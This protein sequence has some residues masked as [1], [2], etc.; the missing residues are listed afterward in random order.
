[1]TRLRVG[2]LRGG[3]SSEYEISLK[4]GGN[5]LRNLSDDLYV[6]HDILISRGGVWHMR[7]LE[8]TPEKVL[9]NV[10]VVFN[11]L[12]G[13][14]GEDGE[15]QK[16]LDKF[17]VPYTGSGT[18]ASSIAMNKPS[19]KD[20][21]SKAGVRVPLHTIIGRSSDIEERITEVFRTFPQPVVIKPLD[22]GSSIGVV[23]AGSY[24]EFVGAVASALEESQDVLVEEF[25]KGKEITSGVV[26]NFRG[27]ERYVFLPI[28]I[29]LP[30]GKVCFDYN[31]K[32][33][34]VVGEKAEFICPGNLTHEERQKIIEATRK[35]HDVLGLR[36]YS[37]SDFI[38]NKQGVY[39]L[40]ANTLPGLT[41][42]SLVPR[43][44]A[45]AGCSLSE[46]LEHIINLAVERK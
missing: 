3:P 7:G 18:L 22:K 13:E 34:D 8:T 27:E 37:R 36:H 35:V 20:I 45:E 39:F 40:E 16:I 19:A 23:F 44:L 43:A 10:D 17:Q 33:S 29:S 9:K 21:A 25:I 5:V 4:T 14:Y 41:S 1:M 12:H 28:E 2:V 32:Y 42:D 11:A 15:V 24:Q 30:K 38:V 26:D 6:T 46:F 31:A